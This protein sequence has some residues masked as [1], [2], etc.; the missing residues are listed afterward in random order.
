MSRVGKQPVAIPT[1][2][3]VEVTK[4]K[5]VRV[6]GPKGQSE[7]PVRSDVSV[8][9]QGNQVIVGRANDEATLLRVASAYERVT[10]WSSHRPPMDQPGSVERAR[11]VATA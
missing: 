11:V 2:V 1:G 10:Q 8:A 3:Q 4:D 7:F 6:K 9:V 5:N